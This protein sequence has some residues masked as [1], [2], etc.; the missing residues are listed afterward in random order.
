MYMNGPRD[1]F[2]LPPSSSSVLR[3]GFMFDAVQWLS[4]SE[5][6]REEMQSM[7]S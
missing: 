6:K 1:V 2:A 3:I 5:W 4:K 7:F